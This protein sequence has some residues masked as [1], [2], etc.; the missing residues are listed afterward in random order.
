MK[1]FITTILI[2]IFACFPIIFNGCKDGGNTSFYSC[3]KEYT[4]NVTLKIH[5]WNNEVVTANGHR[6][7]EK[8]DG[9]ITHNGSYFTFGSYKVDDRIGYTFGGLKYNDGYSDKF[10][11][12][13][14]KDINHRNLW[15][16]ENNRKVDVEEY[17]IPINYKVDY[18]TNIGEEKVEKYYNIGAVIE[19]EP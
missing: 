14:N 6:N 19:L 3:K 11:M 4:G 18:V 16:I 9:I 5:K 15:E 1:K 17:W 2:I 12:T 8:N 10:I 7:I 13:S